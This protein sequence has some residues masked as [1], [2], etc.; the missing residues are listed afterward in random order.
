MFLVY[1]KHLNQY[2]QIYNKNLECLLP[3]KKKKKF[4]ILSKYKYL[5]NL[6]LVPEQIC[7]FNDY[8]Y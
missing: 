1:T 7:G 6:F 8:C 4:Y 2:T 3:Q 5:K